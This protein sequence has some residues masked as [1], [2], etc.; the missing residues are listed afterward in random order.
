MVAQIEENEAFVLSYKRNSG[1][2]SYRSFSKMSQS[3]ISFPYG[4]RIRDS[5][6]NANLHIFSKLRLNKS[7]K[8][9]DSEY[10]FL[11]EFICAP[12]ENEDYLEKNKFIEGDINFKEK[13]DEIM[14]YIHIYI[15]IF[16]IYNN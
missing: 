3:A 16:I 4:S 7:F 2:N 5:S 8:I 13:Y 14:V 1:R 9:T 12:I 11:K 6:P 10:M 15:Y